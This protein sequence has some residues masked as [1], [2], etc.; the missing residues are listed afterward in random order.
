MRNAHSVSRLL[1]QSDDI[2][3]SL[4][5]FLLTELCTSQVNSEKKLS[6]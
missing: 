4:V 5:L 2:E 3:V 6:I 1:F